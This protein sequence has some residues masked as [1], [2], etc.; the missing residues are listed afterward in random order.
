LRGVWSRNDLD[1]ETRLK[2][3]LPLERHA[4]ETAFVVSEELRLLVRHS[5]ALRC[6]HV[7]ASRSSELLNQ[8]TFFWGS[9]KGIGKV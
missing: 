9:V 7:E 5:V 8:D 3:L 2:R 4:R 6:R 1:P